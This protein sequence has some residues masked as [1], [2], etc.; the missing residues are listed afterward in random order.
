[1]QNFFATMNL[2]QGPEQSAKQSSLDLF[3]DNSGNKN[4]QPDPMKAT[5]GQM[6]DFNT[7]QQLFATNMQNVMTGQQS[8]QRNNPPPTND[9]NT[10]Q[11]LFATGQYQ[12][13]FQPP[14]LQTQ[15]QT[16]K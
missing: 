8:Q 1:M 3:E 13:Q 14:N 5:G 12:Q 6:Q 11:Q 7:M 9:F 15:N 2:N 16:K 10:M 4:Q